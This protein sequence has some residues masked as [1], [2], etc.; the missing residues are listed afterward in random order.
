MGRSYNPS[1]IIKS[2]GIH[3]FYLGEGPIDQVLESYCVHTGQTVSESCRDMLVIAF[4]KLGFL[5]DPGVDEGRI[6]KASEGEFTPKFLAFRK[7]A[8][9]IRTLQLEEHF[10]KLAKEAKES[11]VDAEEEE[12]VEEVDGVGF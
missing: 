8:E 3:T 2:N 12:E 5:K 1:R 11:K 10:S 4:V 9:K 7:E 6:L